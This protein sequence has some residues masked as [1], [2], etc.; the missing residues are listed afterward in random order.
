MICPHC[1]AWNKDHYP[2]CIKCGIPLKVIGIK[3]DN[4]AEI[5]RT[6][7]LEEKKRRT[8]AVKASVKLT[9]DIPIAE[10]DNAAKIPLSQSIQGMGRQ[11][12]KRRTIAAVKTGALVL[13]VI[14]LCVF[15]V[16]LYPKLIKKGNE[17]SSAG[18]VANVISTVNQLTRNDLDAHEI[19]FRSDEYES[20]YIK[21]LAKTY[22]FTA[23][24]A[25]LL[26]YDAEIVG[27]APT[28]SKVN[29]VLTP[30][31]YKPSGTSITGDPVKFTLNVPSSEITLISPSEESSTTQKALTTITFTVNPGR[32]TM[33]NGQDVSDLANKDGNI[34]YNLDT[35]RFG[36]NF[37][38]ITSQEKGHTAKSITLTI[39]RPYMDILIELDSTVAESSTGSSFTIT[40]KT[41]PGAAIKLDTSQSGEATVDTDGNFSVIAKLTK[42]GEN[43]V[44]IRASMDG[45]Q[46]TTYKLNVTYAPKLDEYSKQAWPLD[47]RNLNE[48]KSYWDNK[49]GKIY[50]GTGASNGPIKA[51]DPTALPIYDFTLEGG[52]SVYIQMVK[53]KPLT[54][55]VKYKIFCDFDS[56]KGSTPLF[57]GRYY[58]EQTEE[59]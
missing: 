42:I 40:G 31:F 50:V 13:G 32:T 47:S 4:E 28:S 25:R 17:L 30:T 21:E 2:K 7:D 3:A 33:V 38:T 44:I 23:S 26:L 6:Y 59:D 19:V 24:E 34:V 49:V 56:M 14:L 54:T 45:K 53:G 20:V 16:K 39:T 36:E 10:E 58:F 48:L 41:L 11:R 43:E 8:A 22:I 37:V 51:D 35:S 27:D 57:I 5:T 46:D 12:R 18:S 55:G 29:V 15:A 9:Q 52:Q 1:G